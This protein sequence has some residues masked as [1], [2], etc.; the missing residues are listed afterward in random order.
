[1]KKI[2]VGVVLTVLC[3]GWVPVLHHLYKMQT[4][5]PLSSSQRNR[6]SCERFFEDLYQSPS[7]AHIFCSRPKYMNNICFFSMAK[8]VYR[9]KDMDAIDMLELL[10]LTRTHCVSKVIRTRPLKPRK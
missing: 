5:P 4:T 1:M 3:L 8:P 6:L 2:V 10:T 7:M 9:K